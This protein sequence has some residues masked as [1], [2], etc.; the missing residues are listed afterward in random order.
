M[1]MQFVNAEQTRP[2]LERYFSFL[3]KADP[4][5]IGGAMPQDDFY[6]TTAK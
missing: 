4:K 6:Y 3:Y 1:N 2:S 5:F